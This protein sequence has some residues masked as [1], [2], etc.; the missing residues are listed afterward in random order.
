MMNK[1]EAFRI[2]ELLKDVDF[3]YA[4]TLDSILGQIRT[5]Q[6]DLLNKAL[7]TLVK[8]FND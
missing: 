1:D 5:V 8:E 3:S 7:K 6:L 2:L 4:V